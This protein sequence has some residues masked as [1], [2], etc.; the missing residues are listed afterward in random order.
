VVPAGGHAEAKEAVMVR[1]GWASEGPGNAYSVPPVLSDSNDMADDLSDEP[2]SGLHGLF[3]VLS[4]I[5]N[6]TLVLA[7]FLVVLNWLDDFLHAPIGI[8]DY[9]PEPGALV[10]I[11]QLAWIPLLFVVAL[12]A[13]LRF[14]S[15]AFSTVPLLLGAVIV[16]CGPVSLVGGLLGDAKREYF[17][18][19]QYFAHSVTPFLYILFLMAW[20]GLGANHCIKKWKNGGKPR[21]GLA[22]LILILALVTAWVGLFLRNEDSGVILLMSGFLLVG[23][24]FIVYNANHLV[25]KPE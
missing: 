21:H 3:V 24:G 6:L 23:V 10:Q 12:T 5:A 15:R 4:Y 9:P 18:G 14:A 20:V 16:T 13:F 11:A 19:Q 8:K 25:G 1:K 22:G 17:H 2:K 7:T